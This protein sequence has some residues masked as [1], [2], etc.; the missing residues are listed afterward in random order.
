MKSR[1]E[2]QFQKL[3]KAKRKAL[4]TF[5]TAG[6]PSLKKTEELVLAFEKEGVDFIELG[7][8][9]SD[10]LADGPVI[11]ASS[12]RSLERGTTL[13]KILSTVRAIRRKSQIPI[14][15]MGYLNPFIYPG[16]EKVVRQ[17]REAGVDGFIIPDL[18]PDEGREISAIMKKNK[19]VLV[20][21]LAPTS[22]KDRQRIVARAASGFIYFVSMTGVTGQKSQATTAIAPII[23]SAKRMTKLPICVGFGISTP[24]DA[25]NMSRICDGVIIGSAIVKAIEAHPKE[26]A[27]RFAKRLIAPFRRAL[28]PA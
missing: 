17:A 27:D 16:I 21:F 8:P 26:P 22:P 15:L 23:R 14:L 4:I 7:V 25:R 2:S 6:D 3:K 13:D 11:Q 19:M 28:D 20:Y 18:P 10:P 5:I 12:K 24:Q 1:I 9:F